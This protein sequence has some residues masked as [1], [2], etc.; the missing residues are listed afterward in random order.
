MTRALF[1]SLLWGQQDQCICHHQFFLFI[2][3]FSKETFFFSTCIPKVDVIDCK[4][5]GLTIACPFALAMASES[6]TTGNISAF[7]NLNINQLGLKK[8]DPQF[9][10]LLTFWWGDLKIQVQMLNMQEVEV[11]IDW[12]YDCYQHIFPDLILLHLCFNYL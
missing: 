10:E 9:A 1:K 6:T 7:Q 4:T 2:A 8:E 11:D 12:V 5:E 3:A